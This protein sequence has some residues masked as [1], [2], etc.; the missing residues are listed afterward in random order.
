MINHRVDLHEINK[1]ISQGIIRFKVDNSRYQFHLT[2]KN[3]FSIIK[4]YIDEKMGYNTEKYKSIFDCVKNTI[5]EY[6]PNNVFNSKREDVLKYEIEFIA[7]SIFEKEKVTL[8]DIRIIVSDA[9]K[10]LSER[11]KNELPF[12]IYKNLSEGK[13]I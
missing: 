12:F 1:G 6:N 9:L 3:E 10:I 2:D 13:L 4:N 7:R 5:I 8:E 11:I